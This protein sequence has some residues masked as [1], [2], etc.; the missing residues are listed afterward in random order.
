MIV[1]TKNVEKTL[2]F[3][4]KSFDESE[5][6]R[7]HPEEKEYRFNHSIRVATIGQNIAQNEG[8]N[9]EALVIACLLHDISY[10]HSFETDLDWENHGRNAAKIARPFLE[11]LDLEPSVIDEICFGIAIHVDDQADFPG[12]RTKLARSV[13]DCDNLDRFGAFRLY[14]GLKNSKIEAKPLEEQINYVDKMLDRL[15]KLTEYE[16]ATMTANFMWN[17]IINFQ[18][19]FYETLYRQLTSSRVIMKE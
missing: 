8:L 15:A 9:E 10:I 6:F 2:A 4:K 3:L 13:C 16:M 12:E 19:S 1:K 7:L 17:D 5:Y 18:I 14:E 11:T